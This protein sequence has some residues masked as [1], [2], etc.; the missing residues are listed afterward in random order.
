MLRHTRGEAPTR[1]WSRCSHRRV[2]G[3]RRDVGNLLTSVTSALLAVRGLPLLG[4]LLLTAACAPA[5]EP[6]AVFE[7]PRIESLGDLQA[8]LEEAGAEVADLGPIEFEAFGLPGRRWSVNEAEVWVF[9]FPD[10]AA[11]RRVT[12]RLSPD[13]LS[14]EGRPLVWPDRPN[15]WGAGPL[16]VAYPGTD[17]GAILLLS[18]LLGDPLTKAPA[19]ADEPF[20]PAVVAAIRRLAES[21]GMPPTEV[22]VL[23]FE[24]ATWPDSCLGLPQEGEG[25][26]E[27]ETPG[28]RV[29]LHAGGETHVYRTDEVGTNLRAEGGVP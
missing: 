2:R 4:L 1:P 25:C 13:G 3:G 23:A 6:T 22:Q 17:G 28:W 24:P 9:T 20:P 27:V 10:E 29:T 8:A 18:G 26:L 7:P 11:R 12:E 21:L 5:L 15:L 19:P 16:L 14:L